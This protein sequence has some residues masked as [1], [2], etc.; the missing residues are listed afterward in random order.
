MDKIHVLL[1]CENSPLKGKDLAPEIEVEC[2]AHFEKTALATCDLVI[3]DRVPSQQE[4]RAL[5]KITRAHTLFYTPRVEPSRCK[6]LCASRAA[7]PLPRASIQEFLEKDARWFFHESYGEKYIPEN[8]A[9]ADRFTGHVFW[10]G[11]CALQLSGDFG[12]EFTQVA[13]W[14]NDI[15]IEPGQTIDLWLEYQKTS[16]VQLRLQGVLFASGSLDT[17]L[18][19]VEFSEKELEQIVHITAEKRSFLFLS[20]FAKGSG[21]LDIIALHDRYS[22][23]PFG[24]FMPGGRRHVTSR[25]EEIFSYFDPGDGKPPLNVYFSGYKTRE[26]FEAYHLMRKMGAPFLL[27]SESRLEGG[28]FYVG[29]DEYEQLMLSVLQ[30][31]LEQLGF[32]ADQMI[33]SGISMGSTGALYYG[34]MLM[35]HAIIVGKPLVNMGTIALNERLVRPGGFPTSLDLLLKQE[36]QLGKAAAEKLN[37]HFWAQFRKADWSRTKLILSYM[38]EDDYD[39]EAYSHMVEQLSASDAQIYGRGLHGR[40]NDNSAGIVQWFFSQ[41]QKTLNEDFGRTEN[42]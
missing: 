3:L 7:R 24:H 16:G 20:V 21:S 2:W 25:R 4:C 37:E 8:L 30:E 5:D 36:G 27:I 18:N 15:P 39:K 9:V 26:G 35:P 12:Q 10:K 42:K 28:S 41:Y 17:I 38:L 1:L 31:H 14:R 29:E 33:C 32:S 22:R 34:S 40:H 6:N 13:F 11:N 19:T 23:G